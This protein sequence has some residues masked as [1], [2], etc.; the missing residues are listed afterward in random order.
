[1]LIVSPLAPKF[2]YYNSVSF[3]FLGHL[4]L[5]LLIAYGADIDPAILFRNLATGSFQLD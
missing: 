2:Q 3:S 1:M 4:T 5:H